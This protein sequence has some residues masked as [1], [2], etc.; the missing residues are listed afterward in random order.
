MIPKIEVSFKVTGKFDPDKFTKDIR[1]KATRTWRAG[2][3]V[4]DTL[5]TRKFDGWAFSNDAS[6]SHDLDIEITKLI[7]FLKPYRSKITN[8]CK[9]HNLNSEFSC[10]V[11]TEE[12]E[13][14]S[15]HFSSDVIED[16]NVFNAAIDIDIY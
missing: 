13:F 4:K 14:P 2:E 8:F 3:S 7:S 6:H 5:I 12:N 16:I 15:I 11:T 10:V 9:K 1:L